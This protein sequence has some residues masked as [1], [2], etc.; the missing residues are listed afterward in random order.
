MNSKKLITLLV[1]TTTL[2]A[3]M[4]MIPFVG[5]ELGPGVGIA[6]DNLDH[7]TWTGSG[8][9]GQQI[10]VTSDGGAVASGYEVMLYW[11]KIQDWDGEKGHLNTSE[12]D[13]DGSIEIWFTVPEADAGGHTLWFTATDQE[14]K[15][16]EA[17]TVVSDCD[18]ST[19]SGLAGSKV[20]T[21]LWGFAK[22]K[23]VALL[24]VESDQATTQAPFDYDKYNA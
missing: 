5:A 4:P 3:M 23:E 16:S 12:A 2:L 11:D 8:E 1:L 21:D 6:F 19:S 9:K 22:R 17:F 14:T 7:A 18:I 15:H 24:F 10:E 20:V 13:D